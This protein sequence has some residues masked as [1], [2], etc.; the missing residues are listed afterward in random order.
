MKRI[1]AFSAIFLLTFLIFLPTIAKGEETYF[2]FNSS[3]ISEEAVDE[4]NLYVDP[5]GLDTNTGAIESPLQTLDE[6]FR[7]V[8]AAQTTE[9]I[10]IWMRG[11]TYYFEQTLYLS[12]DLGKEVSVR[13]Y[14][15]EEPILTGAVEITNWIE[16]SSFQQRIWSVQLP[17]AEVRA[18][19][20][21][22]G[23]KQVSRWPKEGTLSV[24]RA[25]RKYD[26]KRE[27]HYGF[28]ADPSDLPQS[29]QGATVRL[30]HWWKDELSGVNAYDFTNGYLQMKRPSSMAIVQGDQFWL[31]NVMSVS[32]STGEW[33]YDATSSML[34]Y[35]PADDEIIGLTEL[36]V[37][38]TEQLIRLNGVSNIHFDGLTFAR[39]AWAIPYYDAAPDFP[40]AAYDANSAIW[41]GRGKN[42]QF[43][44]CTFRDIGSGCLRFDMDVKNATVF[45]CTFS[46]IGAH[47][48]YVHG[49]NASF[50]GLLTESIIIENNEIRGY[51]RNFYNAAAILVVHARNID[52]GFNEIHDG[53][54]T[55][56]SAGWV[57]GSDFNITDN[58]RVRNNLIYNIGQGMLS[59]LGAIYML[60]SQPNT[61]I[62]GNIIHDVTMAEY[63]G[64]GIYLDEGSSGITVLNNLVYRCSAQGFHQHNAG[65]NTVENNI[66]AF[67]YDGQV[68]ISGSG[69]FTLRRN[70]VAGGKP[71]LNTSN[72]GTIR[73]KD[74]LFRSTGSL[75][76][77]PDNGNFN[78]TSD[79]P[80]KEIGFVPWVFM[81][82]RYAVE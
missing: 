72:T 68:G 71:H 33:V 54:Y 31:E 53:T 35:A 13:A 36:Y 65:P 47:A 16:S 39:N 23:T 63:G 12:S 34:H 73:N 30:L 44:G 60:G 50:D 79:V 17:L 81:A 57:W 37:G 18:V 11:G 43:T 69:S 74:N 20:G 4:T 27:N 56:I 75:F 28:Y 5:N 40:Q 70:I 66:F 2:Y 14:P 77:D 67:N 42:I 58:I 10:T 26:D 62:S 21:S 78:L 3:P 25:E 80:Q 76:I 61:V 8:Y 1:Y 51:G 24:A 29:L 15:G 55:A 6:A 41:I 52:I 9:P 82:G 45:N 22:A 48:V 38:V 7:R 46:N 19:Y 64:W 32:L 49:E 59:D